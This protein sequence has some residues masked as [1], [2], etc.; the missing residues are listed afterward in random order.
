MNKELNLA[1]KK[2]KHGG[3][4]LAVRRDL[5]QTRSDVSLD[6]I[7]LSSAVNRHPWPVPE[8]PVALWHELPDVDALNQAAK[9]YYGRDNFVPIAGTQQAIEA[10]PNLLFDSQQRP[11]TKVLIPSVGY[12]E[13]GF[14]WSKWQY[15]V[16]RYQNYQELLSLSWHVLVLIQPN[17]PSAKTLSLE[18]LNDLIDIAQARG[19]YI[20]LDEAFIDAV[21]GASL[22]EHYQTRRWPACLIVLRSIGKFFGLPGARVGFCFASPPV[23]NALSS[24]IGP[25]PIAT[26][27]VWLIT[28]AFKDVH[29]Q[30]NAIDDLTKRRQRFRRELQP[31]INPLFDTVNWQQSELFF[32]LFSDSVDRVFECLQALGIHVR[33]GQGWLRFALPADAEFEPI[34]ARVETALISHQNDFVLRTIPEGV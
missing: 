17:N 6:W 2:P 5:S 34:S 12:Q 21:S 25:W 26:P 32:T 3:N 9:S 22:I 33:L 14:A 24:V 29:W 8:V 31:L 19:A 27:A 11:N 7:D 18:S 13:H 20:I 15:Q 23:L 4:L 1:L 28:Q 30:L 10:L 16:E